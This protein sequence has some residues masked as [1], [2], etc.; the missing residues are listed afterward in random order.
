MQTLDEIGPSN[1]SQGHHRRKNATEQ[2]ENLTLARIKN[3]KQANRR[4]INFTICVFFEN[5]K[6]KVHCLYDKDRRTIYCAFVFTYIYIYI[7]AK[8]REYS[9]NK[10]LNIVNVEL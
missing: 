3:G 6:I 7:V 10:V 5:H 1:A 4:W 9:E 8:T 2:I